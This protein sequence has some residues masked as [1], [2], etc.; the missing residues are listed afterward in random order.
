[1]GL[2]E[3]IAEIFDEAAADPITLLHAEGVRIGCD[4]WLDRRE[5]KRKWMRRHRAGYTPRKPPQHCRLCG[6]PGHN[7]RGCSTPR[8]QNVHDAAEYVTYA[9][10]F[11]RGTALEVA[12]QPFNPRIDKEGS[13]RLTVRQMADDGGHLVGLLELDVL[14]VRVTYAVKAHQQVLD[15]LAARL[16]ERFR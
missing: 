9:R 10:W 6:E 16:R 4:T 3:E 15:A 11:F 1:M 14:D 5:Y 7:R 8:V 2:R 12:L 13:E